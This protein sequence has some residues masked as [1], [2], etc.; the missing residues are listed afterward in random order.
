MN[1]QLNTFHISETTTQVVPRVLIMSFFRLL[2]VCAAFNCIQ[3]RIRVL[4]QDV[5]PSKNNRMVTIQDKSPV[6]DLG[7]SPRTPALLFIHQNEW[8]TPFAKFENGGNICHLTFFPVSIIEYMLC[9]F[10]CIHRSP[11]SDPK[12]IQITWWHGLNRK[13]R[14]FRF[15]GKVSLGSKQQHILS[16]LSR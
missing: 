8:P 7:D 15:V 14:E 4:V 2:V 1:R 6:H 12:G 13:S 3:G 9:N 10:I 5:A 11:L 16:N